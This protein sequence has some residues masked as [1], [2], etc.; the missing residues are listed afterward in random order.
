MGKKVVATTGLA[1]LVLRYIPKS[2][3]KDGESLLSECSIPKSTAKADVKGNE[4]DWSILRENDMLL[5]HKAH[6]SNLT[7]E[8]LSGFVSSSKDLLQ[9][10]RT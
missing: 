3:R 4:V 1:S 6:Y 9:E 7:K 10:E 5:V 2:Q 8:T